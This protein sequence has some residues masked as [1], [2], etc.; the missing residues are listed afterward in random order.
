MNVSEFN[1]DEQ[2]GKVYVEYDNGTGVE[3]DLAHAITGKLNTATGV[4][5]L[6]DASRAALRASGFSGWNKTLRVITMGDSITQYGSSS[7]W[8]LYVEMVSNGRV[9]LVKDAAVAGNTINDM[10][11]RFATDV[12]PYIGQAD[13]IWIMAGTNDAGAS[14]S[15]ATH[16]SEISQLVALG[17]AT[18]LRVRL[19]ALPPRDNQLVRAD[20]FRQIQSAV[21]LKMGVDFFDPWQS[22]INPATGGYNAADTLD[23]VHP[24]AA[25][26]TKAGQ[27]VVACLGIPTNHAIALPTQNAANAGMLANP[28]FV[29]DTNVDGLAD[30]LSTSGGATVSLVPSTFGNIQRMAVSSFAGSAYI[31]LNPVLVVVPGNTYAVRGKFS[32]TGTGHSWGIRLRWQTSLSA[33]TGN[34]Y[35]WVG[36]ANASGEFEFRAQAPSDAVKLTIHW[37]MQKQPAAAN[38]TATLDMEQ[39]QVY[40]LTALGIG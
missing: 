25:G 5:T 12:T 27:A 14:D 23:G 4:V 7:G 17:L 24:S 3:K 36:Q 22:C 35:P 6:D 31:Q 1:L 20:T 37:V 15:N 11:A 10:L 21:A 16:A 30:G 32:A 40:D 34:T 39:L 26:H 9:R 13:E 18:G 28:L 2:S 19:F 8:M 29:T 38:Y 33:D